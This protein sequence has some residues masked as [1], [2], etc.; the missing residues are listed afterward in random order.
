MH[1]GVRDD[2]QPPL[3]PLEAKGLAARQ[4]APRGAGA[5]H[6]CVAAAPHGVAAA[7]R[8]AGAARGVAAAPHGVAG[9]P[10]GAGA[11]RH[12]VAAAPHGVAAAP[13]GVAAAPRGAAGVQLVA[14]GALF[15]AAAVPHVAAAGRACGVHQFEAA[16]RDWRELVV[17]A[18]AQDFAAVADPAGRRGG[19]NLIARALPPPLRSLH[20]AALSVILRSIVDRPHGGRPL[21]AVFFLQEASFLRLAR[22]EIALLAFLLRLEPLVKLLVRKQTKQ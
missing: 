17:A 7:P 14:V 19:K 4:A 8:G 21:P 5:A 2:R 16:D 6:H 13:R 18:A 11:A 9:A 20:L 1:W 15:A 3:A 22:H 12:G 10:H